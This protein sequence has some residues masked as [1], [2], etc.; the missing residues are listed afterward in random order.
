MGRQIHCRWDTVCRTNH[1]QGRKSAYRIWE[2][3]W[4]H[5]L[6]HSLF[7]TSQQEKEDSWNSVIFY[8]YFQNFQKGPSQKIKITEDA[9]IAFKEVLEEYLPNFE[10][11]ESR[12]GK[13]RYAGKEIDV[14]CIYHPSAR[15]SYEEQ[16]NIIKGYIPELF[17][18][19]YNVYPFNNVIVVMQPLI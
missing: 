4:R 2:R 3:N 14:I 18:Y 17:P 10:L 11:L 1:S 6:F 12:L 9:E 19:W 8:N 15:K 13:F 7:R 16:R 5:A